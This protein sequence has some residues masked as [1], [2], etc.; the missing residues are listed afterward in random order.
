[1][2]EV[3]DGC[4]QQL[5]GEIVRSMLE[6]YSW[7]VKGS[8]EDTNGTIPT[9][10][11][12]AAHREAV[13]VKLEAMGY[14]V[15][16]RFA[17]R[18]AR[19]RPRMLEPL[20]LI[21]FVCKEFWIAIFKKQIDKL[22]TNHRGVFVVQDF[23]FRWL[24]GISAATEQETKE[25]ALLFLVFPCGLIRG[26]LANLGL[27]AIVNGDVPDVRALPGCLFNIKIKQG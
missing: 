10:E 11:E 9:L 18:A 7:Q 17:E 3:A 8:K 20:D 1:M 15:G 16:Y 22:Q 26:A 24:A 19:D 14:N 5:Y 25:M 4:F 13:I 6:R 27:T 12:M 23:S 21:K 2:K